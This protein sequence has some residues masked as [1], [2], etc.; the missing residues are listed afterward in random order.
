MTVPPAFVSPFVLSS[1]IG[2]RS[3]VWEMVHCRFVFL[4]FGVFCLPSCVWFIR[5][6]GFLVFVWCFV[7]VLFC[8]VWFTT[9]ESTPSHCSENCNQSFYWFHSFLT[10]IICRRL[11]FRPVSSSVE[12]AKLPCT[13]S[14][15]RHLVKSMVL[16]S[17]LLDAPIVKIFT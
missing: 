16:L 11:T 7:F 14:N 6:L 3:R 17:S 8:C 13:L 9:F 10:A 12:L 2:N 15:F 5:N 4:V 1:W